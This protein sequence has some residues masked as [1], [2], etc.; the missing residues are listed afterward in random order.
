[1]SDDA[2]DEFD[3]FDESFEEAFEED[4]EE[5]E[6]ESGGRGVDLPSLQEVGRSVGEAV[7][8]GVGRASARLQERRPL[9]ADVLE[10]DDAYLVVFD[11]PGAERE[12]LQVRYE[13]DTVAV[14]VDRFREFQEGFET[15]VPGR[16]LALSGSVTLPEGAAVE[17][18]AAEA[19]LTDS[20]TL[21]VLVPKREPSDGDEE[22][23]VEIEDEEVE[24]EPAEHDEHADEADDDA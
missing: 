3:E 9:A 13:D 2:D 11:A 4:F 6:A 15:R 17:A 18:D 21:R 19:T 7:L 8:D 10:S 14:R 24:E 16:G 20:G 5:A 23:T 12:D 1:V 22:R